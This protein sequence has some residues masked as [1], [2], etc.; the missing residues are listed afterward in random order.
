MRKPNDFENVQAFGEFKPLPAGGYVCKIMNVQESASASGKPMIIIS[1]DIAEGEYKDYYKESYRTDTRPDKKWGCRV[2][3]LVYDNDNKTNRGFKTFCTAFEESN[4]M[5]IAWGDTAQFEGC[6]K[7]KLIGGVFRREEYEKTD[8]TGTAWAT[9]CFT[10][11][12]VETIRKGVELPQDKPLLNK[13]SGGSDAFAVQGF[14]DVN[15]SE[16]DLPF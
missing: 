12:S 4:N 7:G 10:F 8:G 11:R 2:F 9:R 5:K 1:L 15:V 14:A 16:E 13:P 3:Q 6:F